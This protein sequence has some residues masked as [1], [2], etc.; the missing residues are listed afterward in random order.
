[1]IMIGVAAFF[2][3][4]A[5][6]AFSWDHHQSMMEAWLSKYPDRYPGLVRIP[7]QKEEQRVLNELGAKLAF[8]ADRVPLFSKHQD[9]AAKVEKPLRS[10]LVSGM[11]DE[12]DLG[13]DQDLPDSV[14][15]LGER[16][17]MGGKTGMTSQG[18]RHMYF[19]GFRFLDPLRSF[20]IPLQAVGQAP[21]RYALFMDEAL[22]LK[23]ENAF[24]AV[25]LSLWAAHLIQDLSQ[26]FHVRQVLSLS[27]IP[28]K[29]L[30]SGSFVAASTQAVANY[31]L[32]Y[33]SYVLELVKQAEL[34]EL[35][36][37]F[38]D[39][40]SDLP[41]DP[42]QR[43]HAVVERSLG[44]SKAL[45][46]AVYDLFGASLK[47]LDVDLVKAPNSIDYYAITQ[48]AD[49]DG[50]RKTLEAATCD[51]IRLMLQATVQTLT[52]QQP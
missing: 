41:R 44:T 10:L 31:H 43:V 24:F 18:F 32:A 48:N 23:S 14:D 13:M 22:R 38:F 21:V 52:L 17:W 50:P 28:W 35:D 33:E 46:P 37:C 12:P 4:G 49:A 5:Y 11:V 51:Q 7:C 8:S 45:G 2:L 19:A 39:Q 40:D 9:C 16:A 47:E 30:F 29:K 34:Q 3:A 36:S 27:M 26:P 20:Q 25:R 6:P 42:T 15:P 1:M